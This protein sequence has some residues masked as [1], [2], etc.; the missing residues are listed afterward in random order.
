M[1][2]SLK[3]RLL[4]AFVLGWAGLKLRGGRESELIAFLHQYAD[5]L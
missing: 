2:G 4:A 5:D 3:A 1:W